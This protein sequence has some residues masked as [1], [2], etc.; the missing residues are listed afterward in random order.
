MFEN[1]QRCPDVVMIEEK[2]AFPAEGRENAFAAG[3]VLVETVPGAEALSVFVTAE[4]TPVRKVRLRWI[5]CC[6]SDIHY[7]IQPR[8][9]LTGP[10]RGGPGSRYEK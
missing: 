1:I 9:I 2:Q 7:S 5:S 3:D 10:V 6:N 4:K 8:E